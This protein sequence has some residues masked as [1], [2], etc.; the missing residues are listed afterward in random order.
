MR[1]E[2]KYPEAEPQNYQDYLMDD[3]TEPDAGLDTESMEFSLEEILSEFSG[4]WDDVTEDSAA[5]TEERF[6]RYNEYEVNMDSRP[7]SPE[8][9]TPSEG[10]AEDL[11]F[12]DFSEETSLD[13]DQKPTAAGRRP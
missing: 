9:K 12:F 10:P 2:K 7:G 8:L 13:P 4:R 5:N 11:D 3:G 6:E 1:R